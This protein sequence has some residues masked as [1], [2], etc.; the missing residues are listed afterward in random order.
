M[1]RAL[2]EVPAGTRYPAEG[3]IAVLPLGSTEAH[4]PHLPLGTD[5]IIVEGL[6]DAAA[7][8]LTG[9]SVTTLRLPLMPVGVSEEHLA[10]PGTESVTAEQFIAAITEEGARLAA[11]GVSRLLF[12]NG[13]GGNI[14][15][16][17]I[18][19]LRLRRDHGMLTANLY[20]LDLGLPVD[21]DPPTGIAADVHGGW[22]ETSVMMH[23]RPDLV[24]SPLPAGRKARPPS[25]ILFP[26]GPVAW[27][28]EMADLGGAD[29][30]GRPDLARANIGAHLVAHAA[31][32]LASTIEDIALAPWAP[33]PRR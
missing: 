4:G 10:S 21:F 29:F 5:S 14:S 22:I 25:P 26:T 2:A 24:S 23:L 11:A 6:L 15:A 8:H 33:A 9:D 1:M 28:W 32:A 12:V 17:N 30:A 7:E 13:H 20:W 27:G 31:A 19:A 18:A 16:A 3:T